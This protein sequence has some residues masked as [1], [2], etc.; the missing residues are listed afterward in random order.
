MELQTHKPTKTTFILCV[1]MCVCL[2]LVGCGCLCTH[3]PHTKRVMEREHSPLIVTAL[4]QGGGGGDGD[5]G[6]SGG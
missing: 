6:V 3:S 2:F 4:T 1:C 5:A